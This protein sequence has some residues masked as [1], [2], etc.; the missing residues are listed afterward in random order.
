M[1]FYI[2]KKE[3]W[4]YVAV[5]FFALLIL[6]VILPF[7]VD[8]VKS[9]NFIVVVDYGNGMEK[10]F[11]GSLNRRISAWDTLQQANAHSFIDI[12][13]ASNFVPESID[14]LKNGANGKYW[15]LYINGNKLSRSPIDVEVNV[16]DKVV[17]KYE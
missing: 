12:E 6:V 15:N 13:T 16:G 10:K 17:W 14:D 1:K 3:I 9:N 4:L 8:F 5:L 7:K 11:S 2:F